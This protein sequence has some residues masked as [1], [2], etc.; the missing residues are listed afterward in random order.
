M[1]FIATIV[2]RFQHPA[3]IFYWPYVLSS[4][5]FT[6]FFL[7]IDAKLDLRSSLKLM[8]PRKIWINRS[9]GADIVMSCVY[10]LFISAPAATC[11]V[12][13]FRLVQ[14]Y[15]HLDRIAA[16]HLALPTWLESL[17]ITAVI[18]LSVDFATYW[19]HRLMHAV[20]AL[21]AIH[22]V[23]HSA[24]HLTLFTTHRQHPFEPFL[25]NLFRGAF[26]GVGTAVFYSFFPQQTPG[27]SI[28][29]LGA[30]FFFYMF[31][32]NLQHSHIPVRFPKWLR[33]LA[34]SPHV[35]HIHHSL[36]ERHFGKNYGVIFAVWDRMFGT[37][38]EENLAAGELAYGI[39]RAEDPF[40]HSLW[41]LYLFPLFPFPKLKENQSASNKDISLPPAAAILFSMGLI[42]AHSDLAHAAPAKKI[43]ITD[44]S[45][46][47]LRENGK[48]P[49][50]IVAENVTLVG[51]PK[52]FVCMRLSD[53]QFDCLSTRTQKKSVF[54]ISREDENFV[55]LE[56]H[57]S[58]VAPGISAIIV[59]SVKERRFRV[60]STRMDKGG[61]FTTEYCAGVATID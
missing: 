1:E 43:Q 24:E 10:A 53:T 42:F 18:M 27:F 46:K 17:G 11:Q 16:W 54:D 47:S 56:F 48:K 41:R 58:K 8:F 52:P 15:A 59:V 36:N 21:W 31:I 12:F 33:W 30:G 39:S 35:H 2:H 4:L 9:S 38:V 5:L 14:P 29:G 32:V 19:V 26:A 49:A 25:L 23:H 61:I 51:G 50:A 20:P 6:M 45:C 3:I 44:E 40:Q 28:M 7:K 34:L 37:Y 60:A 22:A 13:I 55:V 57:A